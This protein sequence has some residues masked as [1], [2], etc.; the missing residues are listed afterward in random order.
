MTSS[1]FLVA[2]L[3][4]LTSLASSILAKLMAIGL[5]SN[6]MFYRM[7]SRIVRADEDYFNDNGTGS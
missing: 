2:S 6:N 5:T 4:L 1:A 3:S 7:G